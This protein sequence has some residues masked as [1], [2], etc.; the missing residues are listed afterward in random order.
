MVTGVPQGVLIAAA[1]LLV[2]MPA[3]QIAMLAAGVSFVLL[4]SV[5]LV[6]K[7]ASKREG[8]AV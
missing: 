8:D 1:K 7:H 5:L 3:Y 6:W 2:E 4:C